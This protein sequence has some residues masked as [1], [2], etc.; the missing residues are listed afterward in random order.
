MFTGLVGVALQKS[1]TSCEMSQ[2]DLLSIP[3]YLPFVI[4]WDAIA[5]L[6]EPEEQGC[7]SPFRVASFRQLLKCTV[8][9]LAFNIPTRYVVILI[10]AWDRIFGYCSDDIA[11][12]LV[13]QI[14]IR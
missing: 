13:G 2:N 9:V 10:I 3:S 12:V 14:H 7:G 11:E 1:D 4:S 5:F 6:V 8:K